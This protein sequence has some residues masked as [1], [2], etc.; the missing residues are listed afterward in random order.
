MNKQWEDRPNTGSLFHQSDKKSDKAPDY[1]GNVLI[2]EEVLDHIRK[3]GGSVKLRLA[4]W[5]K[6]AKSGTVYLSLSVSLDTPKQAPKKPYNN[7]S[8]ESDDAPWE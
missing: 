4:G 5:K 2:G 1:T 7:R 6:Q 8:K 3:S